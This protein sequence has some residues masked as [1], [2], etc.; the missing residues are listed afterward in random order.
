MQDQMPR[1]R[2]EESGRYTDTYT[3]EDFLTALGELDGLAGTGD[4]ADR[5]GCSKRHALNRLHELEDVG[6]VR[7]KDIGQSLVWMVGGR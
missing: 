4:I 7:S 1:E 6:K 5:V 2:D 3:D